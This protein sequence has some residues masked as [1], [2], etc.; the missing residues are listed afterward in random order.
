[1]ALAPVADFFTLKEK[2]GDLK[3]LKVAFIGDG[4]NV[5]HSLQFAAVKAGSEMTVATPQGYEPNPDIANKAL[6][7]GRETGGRFHFTNDPLEAVT[8]ADVIYTDVW[9]SMGQEKETEKREAKKEDSK[10][11][12]E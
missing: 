3:N 10:E 7:D 9:A 12:K 1:M 8:D 11:S 6:E 4:N 5:C 2:K